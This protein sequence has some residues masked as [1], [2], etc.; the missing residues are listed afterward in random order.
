LVKEILVLA[1]NIGE[2]KCEEDIKGVGKY[3]W[4]GGNK[5]LAVS[6]WLLAA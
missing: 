1:D 5:L 3:R 6:C 2:E 4:P